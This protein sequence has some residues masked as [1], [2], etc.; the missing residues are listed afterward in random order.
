M[1]KEITFE[2]VHMFSS[3]RNFIYLI[4]NSNPVQK[5]KIVR[6]GFK[7]EKEV[8]LIDWPVLSPILNIIVNEWNIVMT[9]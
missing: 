2:L 7:V 5:L 3:G 8:L 9:K 4:G 6:I 1:P